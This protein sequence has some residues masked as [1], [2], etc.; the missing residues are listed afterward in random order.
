MNAKWRTIDAGIAKAMV[1]RDLAGEIIAECDDGG[2]DTG[3]WQG[4]LYGRW[5]G[6]G[7]AYAESGLLPSRAA[8]KRFVADAIAA[9]G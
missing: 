8:A 3:E 2:V 5:T 4:I 6:D 7:S 1:G 9:N